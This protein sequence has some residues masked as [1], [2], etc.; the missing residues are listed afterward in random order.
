[1]VNNNKHKSCKRRR[2]EVNSKKMFA[3]ELF[4]LIFFLHDPPSPMK[5][6]NHYKCYC[7]GHEYK[8]FSKCPSKVYLGCCSIENTYCRTAFI[9]TLR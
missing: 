3:L 8:F 1:M 9:F 7:F 5:N 2:K 6:N 4:F